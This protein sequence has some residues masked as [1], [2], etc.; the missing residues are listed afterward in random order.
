MRDFRFLLRG[1]FKRRSQSAMSRSDR[2]PRMEESNPLKTG[3]PSTNTELTLIAYRIGPSA[4]MRLIPAPSGRAWMHATVDRFAER[5]LPLLIANQAG[6]LVLNSHP[7]RVTWSGGNNMASVTIEYLSGLPPYPAVSHFGHG[8]L[9]WHIP[10]LF[11]T[12]PGYNLLVR[13]PSNWPKDGVSPLEGIVETDWTVATFTMNWK[14]TRPNQPVT[15]EVDEP[16]CMLVPQRRGELE[17]FHP[18]VL[19]IEKEPNEHRRFQRWSES[20]GRFLHELKTPLKTPGSDAVSQLW[21]KHYF[22]G[23]SSDGGDAPEHQTK[24]KLREFSP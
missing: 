3:M 1:I 4:P 10:Y 9:T 23:K 17:T 5:C 19:A 18:R 7:L 13:G 21:Q 2:R 6:W 16:I 8:I 15:V 22:Q 11:R 20:R 12:P 14:L 24:L